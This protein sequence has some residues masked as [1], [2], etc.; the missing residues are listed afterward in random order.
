MDLA[1]LENF[2][3][4]C[5]ADVDGE[6]GCS[7]NGSELEVVVGGGVGFIGAGT[8][9]SDVGSQAQEKLFVIALEEKFQNKKKTARECGVA[10]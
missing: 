5:S 6:D 1:C 9:G 4:T 7:S 8:Q 3:L 2:P 10:G